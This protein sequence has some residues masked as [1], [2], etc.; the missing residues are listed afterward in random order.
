MPAEELRLAGRRLLVV[1]D[2]DINLLIAEETLLGAGAT[3]ATAENGAQALDKLAASTFDMVLT[4]VQM[5]VMDGLQA[6]RAI[7]ADPRHRHLPVI[8]VTA[9]AMFT[10]REQCHRA[11]MNDVITKPFKPDELLETILRWID[12]PAAGNRS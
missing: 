3:V 9:S 4:D 11:G 12:A 7:R 5:P 1:D 6:T 8:G 10:E 2:N